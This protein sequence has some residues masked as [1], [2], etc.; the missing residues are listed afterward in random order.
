[1]TLDYLVLGGVIFMGLTL[2]F[3]EY[4]ENIDG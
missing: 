4:L 3:V 2:A 1:M